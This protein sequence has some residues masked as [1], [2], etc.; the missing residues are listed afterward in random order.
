MF[1]GLISIK[2]MG[3]IQSS[4]PKEM[5]LNTKVM[6]RNRN[7]IHVSLIHFYDFKIHLI[8]VDNYHFKSKKLIYN[9]LKKI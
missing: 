1:M 5:E 9:S 3:G 7:V 8:H 6:V 4:Y 2:F